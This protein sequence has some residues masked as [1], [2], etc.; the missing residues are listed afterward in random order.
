MEVSQLSVLPHLEYERGN[1]SPVVV[2]FHSLKLNVEDKTVPPDQ[3]C[4]Q[5]LYNEKNLFSSSSNDNI[6]K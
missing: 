3:F 2:K 4:L 6:F 1:N 5:T